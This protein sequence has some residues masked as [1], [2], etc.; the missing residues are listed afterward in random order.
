MLA[1][2]SVVIPAYNCAPFIGEAI[3]SVLRQ[4]YPNREII[5]VDDGSTDDTVDAV[6][7][8]GDRIHLISQS[9]S[10]APAARNTG[11]QAARGEY[12]TLLDADDIWLPTKVSD[13]VRHLE[14]TPEIG[15]VFHRWA[16]WRPDAAG[17]FHCLA[18]PEPDPEDPEIVADESGW[19]YGQLLLSSII[20]TSTIM[21]RRSV[22]EEVG[23]FDTSLRN[24]DDYDYWIRLSRV[25]QVHKL[26]RC[27]SLYRI[28][29]STVAASVS[30]T[31]HAISHEYTVLERALERWGRTGP[32]GR[33]T[34]ARLISKRK[35]H[36]AFG[37]GYQHFHRGT[38][39]LAVRGFTESLRNDPLNLRAV[40]YLALSWLKMVRR[41]PPP[42][43]S[44]QS[45]P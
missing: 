22:R 4:D 21:I 39:A 33:Q 32:D 13:C 18:P 26:N 15:A 44:G 43:T 40:P 36:I 9:N 25:A 2:V 5:V 34:S 8:F 12:I 42:S 20:H 41:R 37:F 24:G 10:G 6:S 38:P 16:E 45:G 19:I 23:L 7:K 17:V 29:P 14:G 3:E 35:A 27:L 31:A 11:L 1:K 30:N 28:I